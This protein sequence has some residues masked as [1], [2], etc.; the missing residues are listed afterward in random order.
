MP[1][2]EYGRKEVQVEIGTESL[3]SS[4]F[5]EARKINNINV[6]QKLTVCRKSTRIFISSPSNEPL[7]GRGHA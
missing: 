5:L 6:I 1:F 7:E 4:E 3:R 2:K